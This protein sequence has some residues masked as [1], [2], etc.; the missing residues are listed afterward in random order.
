MAAYFE[1]FP[2]IRYG[3]VYAR[4]ITVRPALLQNVLKNTYV[5]YPYEISE[6]TRAD[7]L[8]FYY[9]NDSL[10]SW[11][12]YLSNNI[13]DPYYQWYSSNEAMNT[14]INQK[15]GSLQNASSKVHHW[16]VNWLGDDRTL[17]PGEYNQLIVNPLTNVNQKKYWQP[18]INQQG[19][20]FQY[21]RKKINF[22]VDTNVIVKANINLLSLNNF[23]ANEKINQVVGNV[24]TAFAFV[25]FVNDD[26]LIFKNLSG[27][28]NLNSGVWVGEESNASAMLTSIETINNIPQQEQIYWKPVSFYDYE[29]EENEKKRSINIIDNSF[30]KQINLSLRNVLNESN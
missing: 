20:I 13:I 3:D 29:L 11:V 22:I 26:L 25:D 5:F 6:D 27:G 9:Y 16:E 2:L 30:T 14:L 15:Y 10:M 19:L 12:F 21:K 23:N 4:N 18:E 24:I 8:S 7:L 1:N 17:T 28:I